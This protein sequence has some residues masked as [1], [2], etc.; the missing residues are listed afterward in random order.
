MFTAH[1]KRLSYLT[2]F[3]S[4]NAIYCVYMCL[5]PTSYHPV[6]SGTQ[7]FRVK[8]PISLT[9]AVAVNNKLLTRRN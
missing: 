7:G 2:S 9:M 1:Y 6:L 4:S 8:L 3:L 5:M